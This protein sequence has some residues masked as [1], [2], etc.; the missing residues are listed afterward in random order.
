MTYGTLRIA[1]IPA[2]Q[3]DERLTGVLK[4][5]YERGFTIVTVNDGSGEE[6]RE[7]FTAAEE[8]S[9]VLEHT[10]NC[11]KGSAL[12]T[13]LCYIMNTFRAPYVVVTLG[14]DGHHSVDDAVR[15]CKEAEADED[16]VAVGCRKTGEPAPFRS[17]YGSSLSRI[18]FTMTCGKALAETQTGLRA[19]SHRHIGRMLNITGDLYDYE[20]NV[21]MDLAKSETRIIQVPMQTIFIGS[22]TAQRF[23][24]F[25]I[26]SA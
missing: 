12:K 10:V 9:V 15:V 5:L 21:L 19:F 17:R 14:A 13:G 20:M 25:S 2:Y 16:A 24:A 4:E 3:P 6:Y 11:G 22:N 18:V 23:D 8:Y 26:Y 1:L 7:I